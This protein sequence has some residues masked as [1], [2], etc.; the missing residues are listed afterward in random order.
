MSRTRRQIE[1]RIERIKREIAKLD[2]EINKVKKKLGNENFISRAPVEVVEENR[3]RLANFNQ[4]RE[5]L[6]EALERLAAL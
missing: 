4:T 6:K 3:E 1:T 2:D 5:K